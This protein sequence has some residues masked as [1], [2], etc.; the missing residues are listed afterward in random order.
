MAPYELRIQQQ[1]AQQILTQF[2]DSPEAWTRVPD[3]LERSSFPQTKVRPDPLNHH[4]ASSLCAVHWPANPGEADYHEVEVS[5]GGPAA[6]F[7]VFP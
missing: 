1:L 3:V 6:R 4:L 2:Q 7:V 5:P